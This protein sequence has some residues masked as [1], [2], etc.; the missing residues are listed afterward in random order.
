MM[1]WNLI[2]E[3]DFKKMIWLEPKHMMYWNLKGSGDQSY[4]SDTWTETYDVLKSKLGLTF[5]TIGEAWTETYD[6]LK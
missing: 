2:N 5:N 3:D 4:D 6:V 1:Y